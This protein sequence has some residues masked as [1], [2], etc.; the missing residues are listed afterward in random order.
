[1]DINKIKE[2]LS[3]NFAKALANRAGYLCGKSDDG[4][5]GVDLDVKRVAAQVRNG[6]TRWA[7]T[8]E[9][10]QIQLKATTVE[11]IEFEDEVLKYDLEVKNYNDLVA[12]LGTNP[13]LYLAL[14]VLPELEI[15]WLE[16]AVDQLLL[17]GN[18]YYFRPPE[19]SAPSENA[20]TVRIRIP[21][22][23]RVDLEFFDQ[24]C[25]EAYQ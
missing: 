22:V 14:L 5:F 24:A 16:L 10:V 2:L 21:L 20:A 8:G 15:S 19:G 13:P 9:T 23:N 3:V 6:Q 18:L 1:M 11:G 7:E 4:D 12:R 25:I 17:R